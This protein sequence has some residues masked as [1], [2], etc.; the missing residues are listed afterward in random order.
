MFEVQ[1]D[2]PK[3]INVLYDDVDEHYHVMVNITGAMA[4]NY[5]CKACNKGCRR[6]V[7]R[8]CDQTCS[9]CIAIP[10]CAFHDVRNLCSECYRHFRSQECFANHRVRRRRN[11]CVNA[12]GITLRVGPSWRVETMTVIS[13]IVKPVTRTLIW[14]IYVLWDRSRTFCRQTRTMYLIYFT[15]SRPRNIRGIPTR[16]NNM[17]P[18]SCACNSFVQESMKF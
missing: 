4:K 12:G 18:T 2:S 14:A 8:V 15:I 10:P 1:I 3:R 5:V 9:V 17:C 7:T 13:D 16:Q 6:D 11:P